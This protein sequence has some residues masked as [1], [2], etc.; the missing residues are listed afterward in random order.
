MPRLLAA[1]TVIAALLAGAAS[2]DAA[3]RFAAPAGS[4]GAACTEG[5]PCSIQ[6]AIVN[7]SNGDDI[8]VLAGN[9]SVTGSSLAAVRD[10]ITVHGPATGARPVITATNGNGIYLLGD[11]NVVRDLNIVVSG[12]ATSS[13]GLFLGG[14]S[15][16]E[17]VQVFTNAATGTACFVAGA[18]IRDS[19]CETNAADSTALRSTADAT[20]ISY[21]R[22][23]TAF[24]RGSGSTGVKVTSSGSNPGNVQLDARNVIASG[25]LDDASSI[26]GGTPSTT[27][28]LSTSAYDTTFAG[29]GGA[30]TPVGTGT[31]I[32]SQPQ[33]VNAAAGD[34]HQLPTS[35]TVDAGLTDSRTGSTDLDRAARVQGSRPDVG[36]YEL[37]PEATTPPGDTVAPETSILSGPPR[38]TRAKRARINFSSNEAAATYECALDGRSFSRCIPPVLLRK[39]KPRRHIYE[40]RSIDVS[41]NVDPTPAMIRWKVQRKRR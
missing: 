39:L 25:G 13:S 11:G 12:T 18:T 10:N 9:Y 20:V 6:A 16:A 23:V 24:A 31:N 5:D 15:L 40:V 8:T 14:A 17:R 3:N 36:A 29:L 41:G 37:T 35:P 27:L 2:A 33:F 4:V 32:G 28:N 22:N 7:S 19:V 26:P 21:A 38:K 1:V 34:F 30:V